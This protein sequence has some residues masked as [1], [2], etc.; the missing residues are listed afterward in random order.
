MSAAGRK[1][2]DDGYLKV[3]HILIVGVGV[4]VV[5]VITIMWGSVGMWGR[6]ARAGG[7][8]LGRRRVD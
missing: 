4:D 6:T 7:S 1:T 5:V 2:L 3:W 8:A